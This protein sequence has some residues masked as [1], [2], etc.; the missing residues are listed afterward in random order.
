MIGVA[1]PDL[2]SSI[3]VQYGGEERKDQGESQQVNDQRQENHVQ[4]AV[5]ASLRIRGG[6]FTILR[7]CGCHGRCFFSLQNEMII[8]SSFKNSIQN[9]QIKAAEK[10]K[11]IH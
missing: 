6:A 2:F 9:L 11:L 7:L 1:V 8:M 10:K 3:V 5:S 4:G